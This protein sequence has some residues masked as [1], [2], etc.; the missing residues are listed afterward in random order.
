MIPIATTLHHL[1]VAPEIGGTTTYPAVIMM[2][3]RGADEEDLLGLAEHFDHRLLILSVRAPF[4]WSMGGGYTWYDA[5]QG[6]APDPMMFRTSYDRLSHFVDDALSHYPIDPAKLFLF[7][8]SMG[9]VMGYALSLTRPG[10]FRGVLAHSGY[11]PMVAGMEYRWKDVGNLSYFIAH[12]TLDPVIPVE[13][14]R[15]ARDLLTAS[16]AQITYR[17]YP[18]GHEISQQTLDDAATF[19][20]GLLLANG[21]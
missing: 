14:A 16:P 19:L 9:T 15:A 2:H 20:N 7:G 13:A 21:R 4:S 17:E 10:L 5:G 12:G 1:V 8:F 18:M 3:G 11:L 6:G